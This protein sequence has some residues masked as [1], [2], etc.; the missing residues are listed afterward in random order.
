[1]PTPC[2]KFAENKFPFAEPA[3]GIRV[4]QDIGTD[5]F[6]VVVPVAV[7]FCVALAGGLCPTK[8]MMTICKKP[9]EIGGKT[10]SNHIQSPRRHVFITVPMNL[11]CITGFHIKISPGVIDRI[12]IVSAAKK[13]TS[14]Q[15]CG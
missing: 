8:K 14:P 12:L 5:L 7:D 2:V 15:F 3:A 13:V 6:E 1:M 9:Q 11:C 4:A 10:T